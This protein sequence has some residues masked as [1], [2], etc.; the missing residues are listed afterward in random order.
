M[1]GTDTSAALRDLL[2]DAFTR[3]LEHVDEV[4]DGL[5][6][7]VATYRPTPEA[8]SIAWLLWHSARVQDIQV[9]QVAGVEQAWT[10]NGWVDRFGLDLPRDD[11]GYGHS[12]ADVA[13]VRVPTQLLAG[14]YRGVHQLTLDYVDGITAEE[15][16][17]VVDKH[18]NPPVT[19]GV[20]LV[21]V[22][23]DCAQHL[24]QAAY[25]RGIAPSKT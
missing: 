12:A 9:A 21:S 20:R 14:Y 10:R 3:L 1:T 19:A 16:A 8:N 4:T 11:S 23:D 2:R 13:K 24:G 18:W 17:R 6:D 7:E 5:T 25:L 15:L 22:I